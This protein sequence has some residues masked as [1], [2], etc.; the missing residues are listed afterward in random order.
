VCVCVMVLI[1][2]QEGCRSHIQQSSS[3][4]NW[5]TLPNSRLYMPA[6]WYIGGTYDWVGTSN[7]CSIFLWFL[8]WFNWLH[9]TLCF[10]KRPLCI[11][12]ITQTKINGMI[13][14]YRILKI[15]YI[16]CL[17]PVI[18]HP[19]KM[20]PLY[21]MKCRSRAAGRSGIAFLKKWIYVKYISNRLV[22]LKFH[23]NNSA[24]IVKNV[25]LLYWHMLL[26]YFHHY[27]QSVA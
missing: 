23:T 16:F 18:H 14:V 19:W 17:Y 2:G 7:M 9:Y 11:F 12:L 3:E 27:Y 26:S 20:F 24:G 22:T 4:T 6:S 21:F 13:F 8:K 25:H 5:Y 1:L 15:F 10:K